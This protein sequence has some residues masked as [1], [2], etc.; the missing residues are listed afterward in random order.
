MHEFVYLSLFYQVTSALVYN[1]PCTDKCNLPGMICMNNVC[2]CDSKNRRFWTGARCSFCPTDWSMAETACIAYYHT[3]MTWQNAEATCRNMN[4]SLISIRNKNIFSLIYDACKKK[5]GTGAADYLSGW[6]SAHGTSVSGSGVY[7]WLDKSLP[8]FNDKYDL[9]CKKTTPNLGYVYGYDEPTKLIGSG[10]EME[11]CS[12]FWRGKTSI[13]VVCLDDQLC[14]KQYTFICEKSEY[15]ENMYA[16]PPPNGQFNG[17]HNNGISTTANPKKKSSSILIIV[18]I[19]VLVLLAL[20]G[21]ILYFLK[22]RNST[23]AQNKSLTNGGTNRKESIISDQYTNE[24]DLNVDR[25][26]APAHRDLTNI[27]EKKPKQ[28][29][30]GG[31]SKQ[32]FDEFE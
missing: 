28:N 22:F 30:R 18:G 21:G 7:E 26:Q 8:S 24:G 11:S 15:T 9:W 17:S 4:T 32:Q 19:V 25:H 5:Q 29:K 14:S 13:Y 6:T 31:Y 3:S 1:D 10:S 12:M 2:K 20:L 23:G 16:G 27:D